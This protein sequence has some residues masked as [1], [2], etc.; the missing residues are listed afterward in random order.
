MGFPI[1]Q[2]KSLGRMCQISPY[3]VTGED[4]QVKISESTAKVQKVNLIKFQNTSS[5]EKICRAKRHST[6]LILP[7][8]EISRKG[9]Q[10]SLP[11]DQKTGFPTEHENNVRN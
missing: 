4:D 1:W 3:T 10:T 9:L 8:H 11:N 5:T 6:N 7:I 2:P